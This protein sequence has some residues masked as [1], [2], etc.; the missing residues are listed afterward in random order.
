MLVQCQ[1]LAKHSF[2]SILPIAANLFLYSPSSSLPRRGA[3]TFF[4]SCFTLRE[5]SSQAS[6]G[7]GDR[8]EGKKGEGLGREGKLPFILPFF[9]LF[10]SFP[11]PPP[12]FAPA[13]QA[14]KI[15]ICAPPRLPFLIL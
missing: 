13:T 9:A 15:A 3:D 2:E 8:E 4:G 7:V 1:F 11:P 5:N 14:K 6:K 10:P 12:L